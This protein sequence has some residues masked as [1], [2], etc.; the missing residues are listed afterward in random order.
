MPSVLTIYRSTVQQYHSK[1]GQEPY[2]Y[3]SCKQ[4][5]DSFKQFHVGK[6]MHEE[7]AVPMTAEHQQENVRAANCLVCMPSL[8]VLAHCS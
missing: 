1:E 2:Q 8:A 4:M 5:S 7:L 3:V 6:R